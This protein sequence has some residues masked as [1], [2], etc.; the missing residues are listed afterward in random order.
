MF[1]Q[2]VQLGTKQIDEDGLLELL[3]TCPGKKYGGTK[4]PPASPVVKSKGSL[5]GGKGKS[6]S[7]PKTGEV[8]GSGVGTLLTTPNRHHVTTPVAMATPSPS[9]SSTVGTPA[10][11][12]TPKL[13]GNEWLER[14]T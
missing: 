7:P 14:S 6:A 11:I 2:A 1:L 9:T 8:T 4:K 10:R 12:A 13:E 3:R 5:K